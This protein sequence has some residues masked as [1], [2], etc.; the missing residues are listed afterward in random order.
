VGS[1]SRGEG[2]NKTTCSNIGGERGV[3]DR[4]A[5]LVCAMDYLETTVSYNDIYH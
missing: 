3:V 1:K 2:R 5:T 4:I